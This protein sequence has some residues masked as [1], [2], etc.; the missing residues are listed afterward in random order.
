MR[1]VRRAGEHYLAVLIISGLL[2]AGSVAVL[3]GLRFDTDL[4]NLLPEDNADLRILRRMQASYPTDTG[5]MVLLSKN[6]LFATDNT[7]RAMVHNG[8]GW[9]KT[10]TGKPLFALWGFS[11]TEVYAAGE[12]GLLYRYDGKSWRADAY[13]TQAPIYGLWGATPS[14]LFAVG[15]AGA[16]H[17]K[18]GS[19]W[20]RLTSPSKET[21]R[22]VSGNARE[23]YAVGD[24]GTILRREDDGAFVA[25]KAP[26]RQN[27]LGIWVAKKRGVAFAVG[28]HGTLIQR[29]AK[30]WRTIPTAT[31]S[32]LN[33]IWGE[34][35]KRVLIVGAAGKTLRFDG[36]KVHHEIFGLKEDLYAIH[37]LRATRAWT[38]GEK[39]TVE[40][41]TT[42]VRQRRGGK[43]TMVNWWQGPVDS[44]PRPPS[45]PPKIFQPE[46]AKCTA[47][48]TAV[49]RPKN[50][51]GR[52]KAFLPKLA[53]TIAKSPLVGR[54]E[55]KKPVDFFADRALYYLPVKKLEELYSRLKRS[56]DE[57]TARR[58]GL[59]IDLDDDDVEAPG[60]KSESDKL[61][62]LFRK[63]MERANN[64]EDKRYYMDPDGASV[65][66][67]VY[68]KQG[69]SNV[70]GLR[71]LRTALFSLIKSLDYNKRIDGEMRIDVGGD[72]ISKLNEYETTIGDIVSLG[73]LAVVGITLLLLIYTRRIA[74]LFF[75]LVPLSMSIAWTFALTTLAIGTLN[76]VT[77]F[78]FSVLFGLGIDY[79]LQLYGRYREDRLAGLSPDA[80]MDNV[81]FSTG[82][83]TVTSAITSSAALLTL[84]I[85]DFKGFSEFG[86]IAGVGILFALF[87]FVLV[88]PALIRLV[89]RLGLMKLGG[90]K[91]R[92]ERKLRPIRL[93]RL[94][95]LLSAIGAGFGVYG[96]L[97][98]QFEQDHRVLRPVGRPDEPRAR[99]RHSLGESFT[100][101]LLL[102]QSKAG[103][104]AALD[105]IERKRKVYGKS[106]TV[107]RTLSILNFIPSRQEEKSTL[108]GRLDKVLTSK[109][110]RF[111][112]Q[113]KKDAIQLT[114]LR[115]LAKAKPFGLA[116]LPKAARRSF[117]GPGYGDIWIGTV[118]YDVNI[119]NSPEARRLKAQFGRVQGSPLLRLKKILPASAKARVDGQ[120]VAVFCPGGVDKCR[121]AL[122]TA[123]EGG[124]PAFS[125]V[126]TM[127]EA[128]GKGLAV[129][130]G[131][132]GDVLAIA[133]AGLIPVASGGAAP[134]EPSGIFHVSSGELVLTEVVDVMLQDGRIAFVL[135]LGVVFL[136]C[137]LDFRKIKLALLAC[138]P[139]WLGLLWILGALHIVGL[140]LN[141]F[142]FVVLPALVGIGID[143][144]VHYVHRYN[145]EGDLPKVRGALYFVI[146]FCNL[147]TLV[148]FG[149]MSLATHP[150]LKSLGQLALIGLFAMLVA[151]NYALPALLSRSKKPSP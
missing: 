58:T 42:L 9:K 147:T 105:S 98:V 121:A 70:A 14:S 85:T 139:L 62:A 93:P 124:K 13:R 61:A 127:A 82:R 15:K 140:K 96:L 43:F 36:V 47:R 48:F 2:T 75:V 145:E 7:G 55:F 77:G 50:D 83:A 92:V 123:S 46:R 31:K 101:T 103:L 19:T 54:V 76:V 52:I 74:G 106:S 110:W 29:D 53:A 113:K 99:C 86:F 18:S 27:L 51:M 120:R 81:I 30:G 59:Y 100:P 32:R 142:N 149:N 41:R 38:V 63:Y 37:G 56:L 95:L 8:F 129:K 71:R 57:E 118:F 45:W 112:D 24:G 146:L 125:H 39:C 128:E 72:A 35:P 3:G 79:G 133:R 94:I 91:K 6:T 138:A 64:L 90:K 114:R 80:A 26:T 21:L 28:E 17:S 141:M 78:L 117:R 44:V 11:P 68:P 109:R 49:W 126:L 107:R 137:L 87:A 23:V 111:V 122:N 148:G 132:A 4:A 102:A 1:W 143:Y 104:R 12:A 135:S 34:N 115:K 144:G 33:A 10:P 88:L 131:L 65:G 67:V 25:E 97:N 5:F 84:M 20:R 73:W 116:Q 150:G 16:I 119:S 69:A 66:V 40:R 108:L 22:A 60:K 134:V 89:E 130:G 151:S 136:A